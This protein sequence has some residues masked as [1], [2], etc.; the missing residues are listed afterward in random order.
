M[1]K[2]DS[3]V[4]VDNVI[5][6]FMSEYNDRNKQMEAGLVLNMQSLKWLRYKNITKAVKWWI[7]QI[8]FFA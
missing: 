6:F 5:K 1:L 3:D 4:F 8:L 2:T 7:I